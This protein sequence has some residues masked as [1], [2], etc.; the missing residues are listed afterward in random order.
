LDATTKPQ[1]RALSSVAGSPGSE[2][3]LDKVVVELT[4]GFWTYLVSDL[5]EKP[6]WV[7]YAHKAFPAGLE[8][9]LVKPESKRRR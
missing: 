8:H 6:I 7:P 3:I 9:I 2:V 4:F 1:R 5:H